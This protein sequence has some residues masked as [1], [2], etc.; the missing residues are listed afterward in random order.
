LDSSVEEDICQQASGGEGN[1]DIQGVI[2]GHVISSGQE[3]FNELD[4]VNG[5]AV[6][7][8]QGNVQG[9]KKR[10]LTN[11][12]RWA[13]YHALLEKSVNGKLKKNT[14]KEV[15]DMFNI[16]E[17][18]IVQRIWRIHKSTPPGSD[19]DASS[20]KARNCGR[21]RIENSTDRV[22]STNNTYISF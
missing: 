3:I 17:V 13:V 15:K 12:E 6:E 9:R 10:T 16:E 8:R 1:R 14:T 2:H 19:V 18:R 5:E 22:A 4:D 7:T 11:A 20:R 21:K